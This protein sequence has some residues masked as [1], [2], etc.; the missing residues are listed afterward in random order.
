MM[1]RQ[2]LENFPGKEATDKGVS[3]Q[4]HLISLFPY[5]KK[6]ISR[7]LNLLTFV[8]MIF[9]ELLNFPLRAAP[10]KFH[11]QSNEIVAFRAVPM[12]N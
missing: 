12:G 5:L 11:Y 7:K 6:L 2:V 4:G 3:G 10:N 1:A 9:S 8:S